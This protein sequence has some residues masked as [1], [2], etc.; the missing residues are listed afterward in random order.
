MVRSKGVCLM[1]YSLTEISTKDLVEELLKREGVEA[2]I[3]EPYRD[4]EIVASGP[5]IVL[6]VT[7]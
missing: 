4:D 1:S 6:V 3:V 7:D 5:S 2:T